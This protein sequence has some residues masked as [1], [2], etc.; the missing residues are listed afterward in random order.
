MNSTII[1]F[2][3]DAVGDL[4]QSL[5]AI[6]NI[7]ENN[8]EKD[9]LIYLSER[10]KKFSFLIK[11][12]QNVEF[13][14]IKYDLTFFEKI[15][16]IFF[17][18]KNDISKIYILTPK[19]FYFLLPLMFRNTKFYGLCVD[20]PNKYKRP[21]EF[22]RK[23]L[24]KYVVN[25][26]AAIFKRDSTVK[27]QNNLTSGIHSYRNFKFAVDIEPSNFL[28]KYL[29]KNYIY[30]HLK[31]NTIDKLNWQINDL[32]ILFNKLLK[33]YQHVVFTKDIEKYWP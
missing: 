26:R 23:Y 33:Y 4:A 14:N 17:I 15:K 16:I 22:L 13:K 30:F 25:D 31:K 12:Y 29:P 19:S 9:I 2:K 8:K 24:F 32:N 7:I 27:I 21:I 10:S 18:L 1:I 6:Y 5:N 3:N 28:K 11:K 20:G